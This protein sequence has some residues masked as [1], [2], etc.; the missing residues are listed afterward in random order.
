MC[1]PGWMRISVA[2]I[3]IRETYPS[4]G[5]APLFSS[6]P[7]LPFYPL[8]LHSVMYAP[9]V[10]RCWGDRRHNPPPP[11]STIQ[12]R[13][14]NVNPTPEAKMSFP[15]RPPVRSAPLCGTRVGLAAWLEEW[16]L[17]PWQRE[18]SPSV[19]DVLADA[20]E[21][22]RGTGKGVVEMRGWI[23]VAS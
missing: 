20:P 5:E 2:L 16:I 8:P 14:Q 18:G 21:G 9:W 19:G 17:A 13:Y 1:I 6:S 23:E 12:Q 22:G 15:P 7:S 11:Y 4:T 10:G 3:L